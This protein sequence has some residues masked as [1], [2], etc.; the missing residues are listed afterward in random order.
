MPPSFAPPTA[1]S[2][3]RRQKTAAPRDSAL[4]RVSSE[5]EWRHQS[6]RSEEN[7][8]LKDL[9]G[10]LRSAV[11][12]RSSGGANPMT[13]LSAKW[14]PTPIRPRHRWWLRHMHSS[15]SKQVSTGC[16]G[17]AGRGI[18]AMGVPSTRA[19]RLP[20]RGGFAPRRRP[21]RT[22]S[23]PR[24]GCRLVRARPPPGD[25]AAMR[26]EM[27]LSLGSLTWKRMRSERRGD[28]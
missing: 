5:W 20:S 22:K 13:S 28:G 8:R 4:M 23:P 1:D 16:V 26:R 15:E 18:P 7:D 25:A 21:S 19:T 6:Q 14:R 17:C 11:A 27:S 10:C 3:H 24:P 9:L 2:R 12:H